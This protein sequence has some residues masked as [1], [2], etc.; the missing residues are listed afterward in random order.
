[1]VAY[2]MARAVSARVKERLGE[3]GHPKSTKTPSA[4]GTPP[5]FISRRLL[6]SVDVHP[7]SRPAE[8]AA[9]SV[10]ASTE[11]AAIQ[12]AGGTMTAHS[13]RGMRW[14]EPPGTWHRSMQHDLPKRSYIESTA[15]IMAADGSL[16]GEAIDSFLRA[17]IFDGLG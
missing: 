5:A 15:R 11:Y 6:N 9:A 13:P 8:G 14:Q 17:A 7:A 4:P 1:M 2:G 12:E 10:G 3:R 16:S